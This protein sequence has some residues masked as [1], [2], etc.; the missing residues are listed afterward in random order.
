MPDCDPLGPF[1]P[2]TLNHLVITWK[3]PTVFQS[4]RPHRAENTEA[5]YLVVRWGGRLRFPR[6][7]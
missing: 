3:P 5:P 4:P 1:E 7:A 6:L 2:R